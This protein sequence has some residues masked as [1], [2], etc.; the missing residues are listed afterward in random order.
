MAEK[1]AKLKSHCETPLYVN[2]PKGESLKIPARQVVEV[3]Q[4]H[5]E[6]PEL[7]YHLSRA[8]VTVLEEAES[9]KKSSSGKKKSTKEES[10]EEDKESSEE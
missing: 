2:L 3:K 7:A 9:G 10:S 6:S 8:N 4:S 5:L 1:T